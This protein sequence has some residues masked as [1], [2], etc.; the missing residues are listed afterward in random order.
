MEKLDLAYFDFYQI[1][2]T[3][4]ILLFS[5]IL[6][7]ILLAK[8]YRDMQIIVLLI[9]WHS[10]F[11]AYYWFYS[12]TNVADATL[13]YTKAFQ[14]SLNL[15]PGTRFTESVSY[16]IVKIFDAN[17]L[18]TTLISGLIGGIGLGYLYLAI[19]EYILAINR[20]WIII[21]FIPS[22]SFWSSGLGKDSIS[23]FATCLFVYA[24]TH[25]KKKVLAVIFSMVAMFMVRPHITLMMLGSFIIYFIIKSKTH[26]IV[27]AFLLPVILG[28][29]AVTFLYT[30]DYVGLK[31]GVSLESLD[32]Y[33]NTRQGYNQGGAFV[34][35]SSMSY[36]MQ[37]FT[38]V[39]R[40]LPFEAH[41][42]VAL[43]T[44][45]E[46]TILL[47]LYIY[48]AIKTKFKINTFIVGKNLWLFTYFSLTCTIL[49]LTTANLGIATRQKWMFMPVLLYLLVFSYHDYKI[50]KQTIQQQGY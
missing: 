11:S 38:Y 43:I 40:P 36:P 7:I 34:D 46:N 14:I 50:K 1:L 17:Y 32:N 33:V 30:Q 6:A 41:S 24:V 31:D 13:Y 42:I 28:I 18:N 21:L 44:S 15:T 48:I 29:G 49:A 27:K 3:L 20:L 4:L 8:K 12:L 26:V 23:F 47:L 37:M 19:K 16:I 10:L 5:I 22:M 45:I 39:F 2:L 9:I 25:K 35:I